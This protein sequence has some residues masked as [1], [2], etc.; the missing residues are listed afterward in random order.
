[1]IEECGL[2]QVAR[3]PPPVLMVAE[4]SVV[5]EERA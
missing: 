3:T 5:E 1:M 4:I 2:L